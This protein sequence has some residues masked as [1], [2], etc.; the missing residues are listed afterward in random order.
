MKVRGPTTAKPA[1]TAIQFRRP[2]DL[3]LHELQAAIPAPDKDS[4]AWHALVDSVRRERVLQ[5]LLVTDDGRVVDGGFRWR[6]AIELSLPSVP[7]VTVSSDRAAALICATLVARKLFSRGAAAYV[8]LSLTPRLVDGGEAR[9]AA[10]LR[11]GPRRGDC[12]SGLSLSQTARQWGVSE[13]T[14]DEAV[15][16]YKLFR[17]HPELKTKFEPLLLGGEGG[18]SAI[19]RL[20]A[21][22]ANPRGGASARRPHDVVKCVEQMFNRWKRLADT[23]PGLSVENR[24]RLVKSWRVI[25]AGL[26]AEFRRAFGITASTSTNPPAS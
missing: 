3:R 11:R 4:P 25:C 10:N 16:L 8:L 21:K 22:P 1:P 19:L 17:A 18:L 14:L 2:A 26:P 24:Q 20:A 5:P 12:A 13:R 23:W 15:R 9:R 6:A 7:C